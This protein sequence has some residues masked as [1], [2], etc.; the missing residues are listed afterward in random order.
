VLPCITCINEGKFYCRDELD[1]DLYLTNEE[2]LCLAEEDVQPQHV[3]HNKV[4]PLAADKYLRYFICDF[5]T[6]K[7]GTE[8]RQ[9]VMDDSVQTFTISDLDAGQACVYEIQYT[10]AQ[11][12]D[13]Y[14]IWFS[15]IHNLTATIIDGMDKHPYLYSTAEEDAEEMVFVPVKLDE[16]GEQ[17]EVGDVWWKGEYNGLI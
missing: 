3:C 16:E 12:N 10:E 4:R 2:G 17:F 8:D 14:L 9:I 5:E 15:Q 6:A 1:L 11:M 13:D 7:C